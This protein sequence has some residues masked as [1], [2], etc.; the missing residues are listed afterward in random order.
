MWCY[1]LRYYQ[2]LLSGDLSELKLLS[3]DKRI[4]IMKSLC[5]LSKF[6]GIYDFWKAS[7]KKYDLK[8]SSGN[9]DRLII[10]RLLRSLNS[11]DVVNWIKD[12]KAKIAESKVFMDFI[13][14]TGL[15]YIEAI[16]SWNLITNLE[17]ENRLDM[18]YNED[19]EV[20]E[21]FRFEDVFIRRS[22][23]VF[24]SFVPKALIQKVSRSDNLSPYVLVNKIK[25]RGLKCRFG[26]V[27]EYHATYLTKYLRQPEIDFIQGRVSASVFIRHYF[28]PTLID[29]L[30][31]RA[32]KGIEEILAKL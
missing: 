21:H 13:A 15:R 18:Y 29:D 8:W 24:I 2:R 7:V 1:S 27:R 22:K 3:G 25:R 6:L 14:A 26:D 11:D 19:R 17:K 20:L 16:N 23:K 10:S 31:E 28:N 30:K 4:H 5:A 32:L 12:V 9:R